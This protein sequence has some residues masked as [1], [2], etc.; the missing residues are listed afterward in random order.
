[1]SKI[2]LV[3]KCPIIFKISLL[4]SQ[5][6]S[7]R[8][9]CLAQFLMDFNNLDLKIYVLVFFYEISSKLDKKVSGALVIPVRL[10]NSNSCITPVFLALYVRCKCLGYN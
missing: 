4:K 2:I 5:I 3:K 1:M 10:C 9:V 6:F 7:F 8:V